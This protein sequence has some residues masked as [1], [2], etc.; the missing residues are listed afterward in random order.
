M[1]SHPGGGK[2]GQ[3]KPEPWAPGPSCLPPRPTPLRTAHRPALHSAVKAALRK[4]DKERGGQMM[5]ARANLGAVAS[6]LC[7]RH[8]LSGCVSCS[9]VVWA[10]C[11]GHNAGPPLTSHVSVGVLLN[12]PGPQF[13]PLELRTI[14]ALQRGEKVRENVSEGRCLGLGKSQGWSQCAV[15][16]TAAIARTGNAG[17]EGAVQR[18]HVGE[19]QGL[20]QGHTP[21]TQ[22][23]TK[24]S[25][26]D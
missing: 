3:P 14:P 17:C 13:P 18:N 1:E 23:F 8:Q 11:P 6:P 20:V 16:P 4:S 21:H 12:L 10:T 19:V 15:L 22:A 5:P 26:L 25:S 9:H 24:E 7:W 2:R